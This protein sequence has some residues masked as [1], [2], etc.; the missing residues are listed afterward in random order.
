MLFG[1]A[2]RRTGVALL[3]A[4][5]LL[6]ALSLPLQAQDRVPIEAVR[7]IIPLLPAEVGEAVREPL[8]QV[9]MLYAQRSGGEEP[10]A[11]EPSQQAEPGSAAPSPGDTPPPQKPGGSGLWTPGGS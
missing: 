11:G 7:A 6:T 3:G 9:Q 2:S 1:A 4:A 8:S 10:G 5:S